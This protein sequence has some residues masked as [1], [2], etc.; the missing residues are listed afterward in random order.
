MINALSSPA[1]PEMTLDRMWDMAGHE[2][3]VEASAG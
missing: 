2:Q 1:D 3:G